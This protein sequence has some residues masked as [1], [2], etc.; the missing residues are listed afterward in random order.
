[1]S[2]VLFGQVF[3]GAGGTGTVNLLD[4]SVIG[5][6]YAQWILSSDG[7]TYVRNDAGAATQAAAWISPQIGMDQYEAR[8]TLLSGNVPPG[9]LNTWLAPGVTTWGWAG[10]VHERSCDLL[11]EIRRASDH[12]VVD[13]ATISLF[14]AGLD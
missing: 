8:A 9:T 4:D 14:V 10:M 12:V 13:S 11:I 1:M 2:G 7:F 3:G 6:T 5:V